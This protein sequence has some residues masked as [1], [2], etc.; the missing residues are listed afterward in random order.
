MLENYWPWSF[1]N[2]RPRGFRNMYDDGIYPNEDFKKVIEIKFLSEHAVYFNDFQAKR[3]VGPLGL[4][5][6][7]GGAPIVTHSGKKVV[8]TR[9]DPMLR[10]QWSNDLRKTVDN[11]LRY[12]VSK[13]EQEEY[14][15]Q[16]GN[17]V[18]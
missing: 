12:K 7:G 15:K 5:R 14:R 10:F 18:L 8:R 17:K 13:K 6:S 9:E 1:Q 11:T 3:V 2:D 16:L 4:G